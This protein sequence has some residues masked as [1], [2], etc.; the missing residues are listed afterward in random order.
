MTEEANRGIPPQFVIFGCTRQMR[1]V[2]EELARGAKLGLPILIQGESGTGK[3]IIAKCIAAESK[4]ERFVKVSCPAI[5]AALLETELFGYERGAFTG[6][7]A[8]KRG[9]VELADKGILFLD[10]IGELDLAVQAKLTQ[11]LQD[12]RYC[13]V[14]G[15]EERR[16]N[17]RVITA[18]NRNLK[19][20]VALG[21]FRSDLFYRI[22]ALT[23]LLPPLRDR[24]ADLP[25][26][27][28]F[29]IEHY[30]RLFTC[31]VK[32]ISTS[33]LRIMQ[34]YRWPGNIRELENLM[35]RYV[36]LQDEEAIVAEI[37]EDTGDAR[38]V[39]KIEVDTQLSLKAA[40]KQAVHDLERQVILRML[41]MNDWNRK[42]T[43]DA[44]AISYRGLLYKMRDSGFPRIATAKVRTVGSIQ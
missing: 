13:R 34:H 44:L 33:T 4:L 38:F 35:R 29:F 26:L 12:G 21:L 11:L 20:E 30:S 7:H 42:R 3:E 1:R 39:A 22:N 41:Q 28:D 40:I 6:A 8:A 2:G 31:E 19:D 25:V 37:M 15:Q 27:V 24:I 9:R 14:G 36:M 43:A 23:L 16:V 5:P 17:V 10:E 32:P 18:T